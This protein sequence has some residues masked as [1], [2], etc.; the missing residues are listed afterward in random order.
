MSENVQYDGEYVLTTDG[1]KDFG[2]IRAETGLETGKIRLRKGEHDEITDKGYGEVH[3][4]RPR[5]LSQL[6][7]NGYY[8]ARHIVQDV[9]RHFSAIYEGRNNAL[10][11]VKRG[12]KNSL[13]IAKLKT[14][15]HDRTYDVET[16]YIVS[17]LQNSISF[18]TVP[19]FVR[20]KASKTLPWYVGS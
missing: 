17:Q 8:N 12:D 5:R 11:I 6:K 13:I 2:E 18:A 20:L 3:I 4:E 14:I 16:A 9:A 19:C 1:N 7:Q 10:F 15:G